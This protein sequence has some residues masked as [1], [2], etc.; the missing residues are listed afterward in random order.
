MFLCLTNYNKIKVQKKFSLCWF[1]FCYDKT[2][3]VLIGPH[4]VYFTV[5]QPFPICLVSM[6]IFIL[7]FSCFTLQLIPLYYKV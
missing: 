3:D 7:N 4:D 1:Q 2:D 6:V 5:N